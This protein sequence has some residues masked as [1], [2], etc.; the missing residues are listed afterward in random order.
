MPIAFVH[1]TNPA[2]AL[3]T[4]EPIRLPR[5]PIPDLHST[6]QKYVQSLIPFL[7]DQ[8]IREGVPFE[9]AIRERFKW[10]AE[11]EGGIGS[12]CQKR[13]IELD[14]QSPRNWLDDNFW[15]KKAYHE[16]RAP[17]IVNSNWWLAFYNDDTVPRH[18]VDGQEAQG[19]SGITFWQVRRA[20]W[21]VYRVLDFKDKL[22][23][24]EIYPLTTRTGLWFRNTV[25]QMFYTCRIPQHNCDALS[26]Q[27]THTHPNARKIVLM[28]D[29]HIYAIE[30]YRPD[31]SLVNPSEIEHR[32]LEAVR[33][34][35][36]RA[37]SG[38]RVVPVGI[39][40]ADERDIWASNFEHLRSLSLNNARIL[41]TI[42]QSIFA[43]SLDAHT[44]GQSSGATGTPAEVNKHLH[45][46]RSSIDGRNRWFDKAITL[47]VESNTRAG[48]MGEHSPCD[49]L[50]PSIVMEYAIVQPIDDNT[51]IPMQDVA[52]ARSSS[53]DRVDGWERLDFDVDARMRIACQ[54]ALGRA[55]AIIA[56]S[57][58]AVY[59]FNDFGSDWIKNEARLSPDAF[60]QMA[61][62]LAWYKTRGEFTAVYETVLTRL[63]DR[64]RTE[65]IRSYTEDSRAWILSM[66]G[67]SASVKR[68]HELLRRAIQT[69]TKLTREAAAGRGIDRHLLGLRLMLLSGERASL[70]DDS[71]FARSQTWKLSTSGLSAG[72]LFRGTGFGAPCSDGYGINYLIAPDM[73]KFC[74][75]SKFSCPLTSTVHFHTAVAE[76]MLD[77]Q[78]LCTEVALFPSHL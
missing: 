48:A 78:A 4:P 20:A 59:W 69:H 32:M 57:D 56:D 24:Q 66:M 73:V 15:I 39:L 61:L 50:V 40:T 53:V 29:D 46:I 10:A 33:D 63:F 16:W 75:E 51:F 27:P 72:H 67:I 6:L 11:L 38:E 36:E 3:L 68:R 28:I 25:E 54:G 30:V 70:F 47:I 5:L 14:K 77:M 55:K 34:F 9:A 8:E 17:L 21:M 45:N 19:L 43:V 71:L 64:G 12:D 1:S 23:Q 74:V 52:R 49:A 18:V 37:R 7:R 60:V 44:L 22:E 31:G 65:T 62:Q 58:D 35:D 41:E 42:Q 2:E 76:S 26:P 13:L